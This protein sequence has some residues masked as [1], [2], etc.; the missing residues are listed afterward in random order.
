MNKKLKHKIFYEISEV[1]DQLGLESYVIGGYVRDLHLKRQSKD[2]DIVTIGSGIK[3]AQQVAKKLKLNSGV[4]V[5]KNFGTAMLKYN[6]L[7]IEFVGAPKRIISERF[8]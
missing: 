6:D 8:P 7:E 2:I 1:T 3:L 4:S 5:F